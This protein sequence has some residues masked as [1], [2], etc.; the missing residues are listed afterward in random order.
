MKKYE[1]IIAF[2]SAHAQMQ[3]SAANFNQLNEFIKSRDEYD[4]AVIIATFPS[5][6]NVARPTKAETLNVIYMVLTNLEFY[7][8]QMEDFLDAQ[9]MI[10]SA[11]ARRI[12]D[13]EL[14]FT[15]ADADAIKKLQ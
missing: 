15:E 12:W 11:N 9:E 4:P 8:A 7:L 3:L 13:S 14:P 6:A 1:G 5:M 2:V 10:F